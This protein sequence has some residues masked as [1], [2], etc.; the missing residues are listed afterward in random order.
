LGAEDNPVRTGGA[1]GAD[2]RGEPT[3]FDGDPTFDGGLVQ[4]ISAEVLLRLWTPGRS[5]RPLEG[6]VEDGGEEGVK[7]GGGGGLQ[8]SQLVEIVK[9]S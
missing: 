9:C 7:L 8:G 5:Q 4:A 6:A 3:V 1:G 2:R